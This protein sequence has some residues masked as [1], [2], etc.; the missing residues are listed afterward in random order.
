MGDNPPR[1]ARV[2]EINGLRGS[3]PWQSHCARFITILRST[4]SYFSFP[5]MLAPEFATSVQGAR[6]MARDGRGA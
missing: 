1:S 4:Q 2:G 3:A 5:V 6:Q